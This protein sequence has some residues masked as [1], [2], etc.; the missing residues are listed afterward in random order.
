[1]L[2]K[3]TRENAEAVRNV[4]LH[5]IEEARQMGVPVR[6]IDCSLGEGIIR[7]MPDGSRQRVKR[8]DGEEVVVEELPPRG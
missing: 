7:E 2:S 6:Y 1:M 8:V 4:G 3:K 5:A